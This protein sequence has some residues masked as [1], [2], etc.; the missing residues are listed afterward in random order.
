MPNWVSKQRVL[1]ISFEA[2]TS[3]G[4][5]VKAGGLKGRSLSHSRWFGKL[6]MFSYKLAP[7]DPFSMCSDKYV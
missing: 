3:G 7:H 1:G 6:L 4:S 5:Q 2:V